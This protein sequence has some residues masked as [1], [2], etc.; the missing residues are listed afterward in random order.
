[1][2]VFLPERAV[3]ISI[4]ANVLTA[5]YQ[6][7]AGVAG[8]GL[9][10]GGSSGSA[11][12][13]KKNPTPPWTS[14]S[15]APQMSALTQKVLAGGKFIDEGA[16]QLD[17][18]KASADYKRLFALYQGL[19]ALEGIVEQINAKGISDYRK[20]ELRARFDAGMKE[21][22]AYIDKTRFDGFQLAQGVTGE[23]LQSSGLVKR[24]TDAYTTVPLHS[25]GAD[26]E[27][28]A[29]KGPTAFSLKLT[30]PSGSTI[31]VA[32]D[33]AEMGSTPRTMAN[34]VQ[35][36]N[37]KL[38]AAG[39]YS[40]FGI[41]RTPGAER[42]VQ[43]GKETVSLGPGPETFS[44]KFKGV[45]TEV[46]T[47]TA[48]ATP[49]VYIGENVG[50]S[51]DQ[52]VKFATDP[53]SGATSAVDG[54]VFT[55]D[56]GEQTVAVRAS[57]VAAD[58]SLYVLGD[59]NGSP[60]GQ[61]IKGMT[62]VVLR[63]YDSA[64]N[65]VFTRTLGAQQDASGYALAVSAD[66]SRIAIAGSVTGALDNGEI[67]TDAAT[68]DSFVTVF[69]AD[70]EEIFTQRRGATAADQVN[71]LTFADDGTLYVAGT[72]SSGIGGQAGQGGQDAYVQ[73]FK[74]NAKGA[75]FAYSQTFTVQ[76]GT[77]GTDKVSGIAVNGS[78][79]VVAGLENGDVVAR[80]YDL[81]ATGAPVLG[82]VRNLGGVAGGT[83]AGVGFAD[84]G[85]VLIAGSTHNGS[86]SVGAVTTAYASGQAAFVAKLSSDLNAGGSERLTYYNGASDLTASAMTVAGGKVYVT[87]QQKVAPPPGQTTAFDGYA[88]AID[89]DTGAVSWSQTFR[90]DGRIASPTTISV[91]TTGA[92]VLDRLGLPSGTMDFIQ[93]QS[94]AAN[95]AARPGDQFFVRVSGTAKA[96]TIE[97]GDTLKSVAA[98]INRAAGFNVKAEVVS[99][100]GYD[101]IKITPVSPRTTVEVE[102]GPDNRNALPALGLKEGIVTTAADKNTKDRVKA[103][104][105]LELPSTLNLDTDGYAK[106]AQ[107][108]LLTAMSTIKN[109]YKDM[110]YDPA[111]AKPTGT[112]P[113]YLQNQI[114]NY[115]QALNRLTGGG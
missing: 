4:D 49:A 101:T 13:A 20:N 106:Q 24:E 6:A 77:T 99:A 47:F 10:S 75:A 45:S 91:D 51:G 33:L 79:L 87:G 3:V 69:D 61:A 103:S 31:D 12:G 89:A 109:I 11:S 17:V 64:G 43:A 58:G 108:V 94:V 22:S 97:A 98:K 70:G 37:G 1:L 36:M 71:A 15:T 60:D 88:A 66:G 32:F 50:T 65:L 30:K 96:V 74:P 90:G 102:A 26:T 82:A 92:S 85:S 84:D 34:V 21:I 59:A 5:Y 112:V 9:A 111:S 7:R 35:Y 16:A 41:E 73:G 107:A 115:Q 14:T 86:L 23:K 72:T 46:P 38:E 57:A 8:A 19:N 39:S 54:K 104:Y 56:L 18:P 29:F 113:A 100:D 44:L 93:S 114:A 62:D 78:S 42:T 52:L 76:Y 53:A 83:V 68:A 25:G 80:R 95:T 110:T 40:R 28:D 2:A 81:Q 63:K 48:A 27:V 105:A 67:R 55:K